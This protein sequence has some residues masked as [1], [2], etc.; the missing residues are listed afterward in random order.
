ML[1]LIPAPVGCLVN[2]VHVRCP[3][4]FV[5]ESAHVKCAGQFST[6]FDVRYDDIPPG[7]DDHKPANG[8]AAE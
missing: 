5:R 1:G 4:L 6:G 3:G 7:L 8:G 2:D